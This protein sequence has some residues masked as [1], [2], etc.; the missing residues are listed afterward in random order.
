MQTFPVLSV[1]CLEGQEMF[2]LQG[3]KQLFGEGRAG[4][5]PSSSCDLC[6]RVCAEDGFN[7]WR[8]SLEGCHCYVAMRA[9]H[10]FLQLAHLQ[11]YE[12]I[13]GQHVC[14]SDNCVCLCR[15]VGSLPTCPWGPWC[16]QYSQAWGLHAAPRCGSGSCSPSLSLSLPC[17]RLG[18]ECGQ[19]KLCLVRAGGWPRWRGHCSEH[20]LWAREVGSEL[21]RVN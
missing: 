2:F 10:L 11:K 19:P 1:A 21:C 6:A 9:P 20:R 13:A 18:R 5:A 15:A 16:G 14:R 7:K 3:I 8:C 12:I 17:D 4:M